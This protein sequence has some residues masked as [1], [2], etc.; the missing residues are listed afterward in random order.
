MSES[1]FVITIDR[2]AEM[3]GEDEDFLFEIACEMTPTEGCINVY[4]VDDAFAVAFTPEGIDRLEER[5]SASKPP[6]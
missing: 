2:V 1:G 5:I 3:L 6:N 4:G